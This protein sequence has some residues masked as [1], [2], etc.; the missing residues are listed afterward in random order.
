M[1][2]VKWL[3]KNPNPARIFILKI[4]DCV[5]FILKVNENQLI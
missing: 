3:E 1:L 5:T 4:L 2:S